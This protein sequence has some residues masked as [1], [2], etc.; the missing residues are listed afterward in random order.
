M[1]DVGL[2]IVEKGGL[3]TCS[4]PIEQLCEWILRLAHFMLPA[5]KGVQR[6]VGRTNGRDM[7]VSE[8]NF[9]DTG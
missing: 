9:A 3:L 2:N 8:P 7:R 4:I 6:V 1:S 5:T